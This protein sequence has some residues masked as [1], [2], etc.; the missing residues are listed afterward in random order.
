MTLT[1]AAIGVALIGACLVLLA[2]YLT[3]GDS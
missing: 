1:P 2:H 3:R